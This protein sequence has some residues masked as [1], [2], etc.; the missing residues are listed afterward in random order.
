MRSRTSSAAARD[1]VSSVNSAMTSEL[2]VEERD[3]TFLT[4]AMAPMLSSI[5]RLTC[6]STA[7]AEAPSKLVET[8]TAGRSIDGSRSTGRRDQAVTPSTTMATMTIVAK[9]GC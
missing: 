4:P 2:P 7:R 1:G 6:C 5:G 9:T 3:V 8:T